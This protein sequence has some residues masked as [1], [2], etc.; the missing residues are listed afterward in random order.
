VPQIPGTNTVVYNPLLPRSSRFASFALKA[1]DRTDSAH[2]KLTKMICWLSAIEAARLSG[3][4]SDGAA[5]RISK[6]TRREYW[7]PFVPF[8]T[9]V[10]LTYEQLLNVPI[11]SLLG[12]LA[13]PLAGE[14][15]EQGLVLAHAMVYLGAGRAV[16][17]NNGVIGGQGDWSVMDLSTLPWNTAPGQSSFALGQRTFTVR[18]RN[19]EDTERRSCIIM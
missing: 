6:F 10:V 14:A 18:C 19:I 15:G 8:D 16:G 1:A 7:S 11:G 5:A 12:F 13:N 3:A 17:S 9:D 4:I 2:G